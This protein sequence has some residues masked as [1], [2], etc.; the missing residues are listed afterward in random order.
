MREYKRKIYK[1]RKEIKDFKGEFD[2]GSEQIR[3]I[4]LRHARR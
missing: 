2:S 4:D 1:I 3:S